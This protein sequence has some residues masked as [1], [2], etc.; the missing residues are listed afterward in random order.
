MKVTYLDPVEAVKADVATRRA[1][2]IP[3]FL[4]YSMTDPETNFQYANYQLLLADKIQ[5]FAERGE[6]I[7]KKRETDL[8]DI[9]F[10]IEE[11]YA[12]EEKMPE[13]LKFLYSAEDWSKVLTC[14][15]EEVDHEHY[16]EMLESL[17]IV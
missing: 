4:K 2:H 3:L 9:K 16:M 1:Q 13:E 14:L 10:C 6:K 5:T 17:D 11:M 15:K 12:R 7:D 8:F